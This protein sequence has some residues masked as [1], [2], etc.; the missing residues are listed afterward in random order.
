MAELKEIFG[1]DDD[2]RRPSLRDLQNMK[3][4]ERC[5]KETLR[6]YPSVPLL[7]RQISDDIQ[8]GNG[9]KNFE[10]FQCA[11]MYV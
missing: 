3:Y 11:S 8:I 7:A 2:G 10:I 5:I 9:N 1:E 6:L 4:L